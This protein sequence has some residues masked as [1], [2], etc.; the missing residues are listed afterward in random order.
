MNENIVARIEKFLR[1]VWLWL[2][3]IAVAILWVSAA[4]LVSSTNA[5]AQELGLFAIKYISSSLAVI[6]IILLSF[7]KYKSLGE[8]I[9]ILEDRMNLK[10]ASNIE[11]TI[12]SIQTSLES[13]NTLTPDDITKLVDSLKNSL[14]KN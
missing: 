4:Y 1:E 14:P 8:R 10:T 5:T 3:V 9:S 11:G 7:G 2:I 13:G 12:A 6:G